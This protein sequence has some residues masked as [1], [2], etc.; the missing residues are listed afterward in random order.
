MELYKLVEKLGYKAPGPST[1]ELL[2]MADALIN[3]SLCPTNAPRQF[4]HISYAIRL[5]WGS[6]SYNKYDHNF[7]INQNRF[8]H[9]INMHYEIV[10]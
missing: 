5:N 7:L 10:V 4:G 6:E 2:S 1:L 3:A 9:Q 8:S